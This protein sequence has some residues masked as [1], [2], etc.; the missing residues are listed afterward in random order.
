MTS[1]IATLELHSLKELII[2][3]KTIRDKMNDLEEAQDSLTYIRQNTTEYL[4]LGQILVRLPEPALLTPQT[5]TE[6]DISVIST[7]EDTRL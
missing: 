4:T 6:A 1:N 3:R 7:N 2:L 5:C